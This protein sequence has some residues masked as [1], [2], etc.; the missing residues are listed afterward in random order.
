[1]SRK[2]F[3]RYIDEDDVRS[4][5]AALTREAQWIEEVDVQISACRDPKDNKFLDLA[6]SGRATH[7]ITGDL[8]LLVLNPFRGIYILSPREFLET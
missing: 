7:I 6:V 4:L 8:D 3:R 1:L 2:L 5:L